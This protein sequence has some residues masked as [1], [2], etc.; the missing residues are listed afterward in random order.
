MRCLG[1]RRGA[2]EAA[3]IELTGLLG[4][5]PGGQREVD[6]VRL[7][8]ERLEFVGLRTARLLEKLFDEAR[9]QLALSAPQLSACWNKDHVDI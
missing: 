1:A 2:A 4:Q 5:V 3:G 7:G 8:R 9:G 6:E